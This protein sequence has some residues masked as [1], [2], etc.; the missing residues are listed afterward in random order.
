V[1]GWVLDDVGI[2][3][4]KIYRDPENGGDNLVYIGDAVL[5][6][7]ARPDVEHAYPTYP[8]N[9][10]AGWGYMMLTNFLPNSGNGTFVIYAYAND[11][12]GHSVSLGSKTIICDNAHAVKP[13]G[14][15]DVPGQG[16]DTSGKFFN[17]GWALTPIPNKIPEDGSTINV[18]VDGVNIGHPA[19]NQYRNDIATLF[20]GYA[21]SGGAVGNYYLDTTGYTNGVHTIAW[22]VRD[23]A[24]NTDGIGSRFFSITNAGGASLVQGTAGRIQIHRGDESVENM[25]RLPVNFNALR[26]R[27]G[28][29]KDD[30]TKAVVPDPYGVTEILIKEVERIVIELGKGSGYRGYMV[31]GDELRPL[32]VGST[33]DTEN[34][35]FYWQ[36]GPGFIG[37]YNLVFVGID[38]F[39][40]KRKT[41]VKIRIR[42]KF[43]NP[44]ID[45]FQNVQTKG[46]AASK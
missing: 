12:D 9:Y 45:L 26:I 24:G 40:I 37:D 15:I 14:A 44:Q 21:N 31:V 8:M 25:M 27:K 29:R 2:E 20:P 4:V 43:G 22:S 34:G 5:V 13:F 35:I 32:P 10:K 17:T 6:E 23:D 11:L 46:K 38:E 16:N 36:P 18:F 30:E 3:S 28:F 41:Q 33:L 7:G 1:T 42:P 39:G 19:Y